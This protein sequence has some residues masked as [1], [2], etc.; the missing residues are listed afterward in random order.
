MIWVWATNWEMGYDAL[1][2]K[3]YFDVLLA[4]DEALPRYDLSW[5]IDKEFRK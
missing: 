5:V 4:E 1:E 2:I 3:G